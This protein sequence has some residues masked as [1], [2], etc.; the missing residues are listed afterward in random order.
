MRLLRLIFLLAVP[1]AVWGQTGDV[2]A[3]T[4]RA[5][6]ICSVQ[7]VSIE[8]P[9]E[10]RN[11]FLIH[12]KVDDGLRGVQTGEEIPLSEWSGRW[13]AGIARWRVGESFLL[14]LGGTK[15]S[16]SVLDGDAGRLRVNKGMVTLDSANS[17]RAMRLRK[18]GA[19]LS[20]VPYREVADQI[21]AAMRE[22]Q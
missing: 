13:Q 5:S 7:V 11:T 14:F 6:V 1:A 9:T 18:T 10:S 21:R 15:G 8:A 22:R 2:S 3:L 4:K 19:Q 12:L 16:V 17:D 20:Q